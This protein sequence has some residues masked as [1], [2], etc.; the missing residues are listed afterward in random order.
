MALVAGSM[1]PGHPTLVRQTATCVDYRDPALQ[2][3][4][5]KEYAEASTAPYVNFA[6]M[7]AVAAPGC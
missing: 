2:K 6:T 3:L 1:L 7:Q 5:G 4:I